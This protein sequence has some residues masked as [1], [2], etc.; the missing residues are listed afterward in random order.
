MKNLKIFFLGYLLLI[1]ALSSC[2]ENITEPE[3]VANS[4]TDE[5]LTFTFTDEEVNHLMLSKY[6][7][8]LNTIEEKSDFL[9]NHIRTNLIESEPIIG[10]NP[11]GVVK[12]SCV[13]GIYSNGNWTFN[14]DNG[15]TDELV[16]ASKS[17]RSSNSIV[18]GTSTSISI[19]WDNDG[20]FGLYPDYYNTAYKEPTLPYC[21]DGPDGTYGFA[22]AFRTSDG[23]IQMY[24]IVKCD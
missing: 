18:V 17:I 9:H 23:A 10:G 8:S 6:G 14:V 24:S 1:I 2:E 5:N 15:Y 11:G 3:V 7:R 21:I 13:A 16:S 12:V 19:D 20:A 4:K 22:K